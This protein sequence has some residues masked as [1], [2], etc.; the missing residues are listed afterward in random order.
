MRAVYSIHRI[1]QIPRVFFIAQFMIFVKFPP[2]KTGHIIIKLHFCGKI[3]LGLETIYNL[4]FLFRLGPFWAQTS[5][6][7]L[8]DP[9][10]K[11]TQHVNMLQTNAATQGTPLLGMENNIRNSAL[12]STADFESSRTWISSPSA[13]SC[14]EPTWLIESACRRNALMSEQ[15]CEHPLY[16]VLAVKIMN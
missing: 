9:Q 6:Q 16:K 5:L 8:I 7:S 15:I 13:T 1:Q 3:K 11:K 4:R 10:G 14:A 2:H 12:Q